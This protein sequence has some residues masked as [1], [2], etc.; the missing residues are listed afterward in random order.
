MEDNFGTAIA[1]LTGLTS[2]EE[3]TVAKIEK[4]YPKAP[5]DYLRFL[6]EAGYGDVGPYM[7]YSG[8]VEPE[9]IYGP[10]SDTLRGKVILFGD[11]RALVSVGFDL[12]SWQVVEIDHATK[13]IGFV[14]ATFADFL[15]GILLAEGP[16]QRH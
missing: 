8:L 9:E 5:S 3:S 10:D 11:D 13:A 4:S 2:V 6:R 7:I 15:F 12:H 1:T 16:R 14:A